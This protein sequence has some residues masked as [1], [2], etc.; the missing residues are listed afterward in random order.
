[1]IFVSDRRLSVKGLSQD[2]R[3]LTTRKHAVCSIG[4]FKLFLGRI[5]TGYA[6]MSS[7]MTP[8]E[9]L[10]LEIGSADVL[11]ADHEGVFGSPTLIEN[12]E[13]VKAWVQ[14]LRQG[15]GEGYV[16]ELTRTETSPRPSPL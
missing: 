2:E 1:M 16:Q 10:A 14:G 8:D 15:G 12:Q 6:G 9:H 3:R 4:Q 7:S 5:P 11:G 13:E